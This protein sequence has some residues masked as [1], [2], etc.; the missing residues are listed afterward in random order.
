[1]ATMLDLAQIQKADVRH[2]PYPYFIV[3][4]AIAA[5]KAQAAA[6]SFPAINR[7][8]AVDIKETNFGPPF[9]ALIDDLKSAAF[10]NIIAKKLDVDLDG[11]DIVVNVRGQVR[12]TDG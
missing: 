1:M 8:G 6:D 11:K 9:A 3:R 5:D 2:S 10:R 7:P 4:D 12:L